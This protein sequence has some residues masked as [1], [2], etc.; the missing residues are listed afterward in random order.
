MTVNADGTVSVAPNT[1]AGTYTIEYTICEVDNP[2][3]CDTGTVTVVVDP[4]ANVIDAVDDDFSAE[5][6]DGTSGG[7]V[8]NSN[9]LTNDTLNGVAV[10]PSDVTFY[11][12]S[13]RTVN[14]KC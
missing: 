14:S 4:G 12:H 9:V 2:T 7:V 1:A 6:V 10:D 8:A 5:P 11:F 13:N 3:N